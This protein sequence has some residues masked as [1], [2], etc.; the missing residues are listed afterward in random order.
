M[1]SQSVS[2]DTY[3]EENP[4]PS[5]DRRSN[6]SQDEFEKSYL[7]P[8][9]PVIFSDGLRFWN[10]IQKWTPDFFKSQFPERKVTIDGATYTIREFIDLIKH[11]SFENPAPYL[12]AQKIAEVFP[13]LL[14]EIQALF[15]Y[16]QSNWG[17]S[18]AFPGWIQRFVMPEILIGGKGGRFH[19]LHYDNCHLHAYVAQVFGK[20][21]F[22]LLPP[23]QTPYVYPDPAMP[24]VSLIKNIHQPDYNRFPLLRNAT[25]V[26]ETLEPGEV[27]FVPSGWWHTTL[28]PAA[29]VSITWNQVN[30]SNWDKFSNDIKT[31]YSEKHSVLGALFGVYGSLIKRLLK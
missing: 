15:P 23:D 30:A 20:K 19:A 3:L 24:N 22:F 11:S 12:R 10:T 14:P 13:E 26:S 9:R 7:F 25:F 18:K 4:K 6:L 8:N 21:Q 28:M 29:S 5:I 1:S 17:Q 27:V 16:S 2:T 31:V